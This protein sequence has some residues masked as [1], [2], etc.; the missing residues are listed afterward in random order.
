[1][2]CHS[3]KVV[4]RS[5]AHEK[6]TRLLTRKL[7][8][9]G[10]RVDAIS[11]NDFGGPK[12]AARELSDADVVVLSCG[13][14][15][16]NEILSLLR[17]RNGKALTVALF[18]GIVVPEQ[19]EAFVSR[20]RCS[21]TL[22]NSQFDARIYRRVC[23]ALGM[24]DNGV[25]F[26]AAW[27]DDI[28]EQC[29]VQAADTRQEFEHA[30]LMK[31]QLKQEST[32]PREPEHVGVMGCK[33][34]LENTT[35]RELERA[36]ARKR[37]FE[38]EV[39]PVCGHEHADVADSRQQQTSA[40]P[41]PPAT[42]F[43]EQVD[44]PYGAEQR[45]RLVDLLIALATRFPARTFYIKQRHATQTGKT[46]DGACLP[47]ADI[48][49]SKP[50]LPNNLQI[51]DQDVS[52]LLAMADSCLT[53]SSSA[54]IE[55]ILAGKRVYILGDFASRQNFTHY[56]KNSGLMM[57]ADAIDFC[58]GGYPTKTWQSANV[59]NPHACAEAVLQRVLNGT[60][61]PRAITVKRPLL[62][63]CLFFPLLCLRY[64]RPLIRRVR[65]TLIRVQ[66]G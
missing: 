64:G 1:M 12:E 27:W 46:D 61:Q 65:V 43:F 13:G 15:D 58:K 19:L 28:D 56:F 55:G 66:N 29:D 18:P 52:Q 62:R 53:I 24:P 16:I 3:I 31:R 39:A 59:A 14:K 22:L 36:D 2:K 40:D 45:A 35:G 57:P 10:C 6:A 37:D 20:V 26:G 50:R 30:N 25:V 41:C 63:L 17:D 48:L 7:R 8:E 60:A 34:E 54:G 49:N 11:L 32:A 4:Y 42:V 44:V 33:P 47:L 21:I 5:F 23:K 51:T 38:Q 9:A